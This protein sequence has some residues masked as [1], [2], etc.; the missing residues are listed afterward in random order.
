M[1]PN[2]IL[3]MTDQQRADLRRSRG[4]ELD[5]MPFLD[6]WAKGGVDFERSYTPNPICIAA[7]VS[8]FTGRTPETHKV[9]TNHN[10]MDATYTEDLLDVLRKNGYVTALCGK[11]HTHHRPAE[12]DFAKTNGHLGGEGEINQT[13]EEAEFANFLRSSNHMES[14]SPSPFGVEVQFPYR[15]VRDAL[16]FL[17]TRDKDRPFFLWVS[18][19]EPHNP[20]QV[21]EPY[22]DMFPPTELPE[23]SGPEALEHKSARMNWIRHT[24]EEVLG[25]SIEH[26]IKRT[27]SNYYGMLR[28]I[29]GQ[30]ERLIKGVDQRGLTDSTYI[31]YLSDHGDFV[32]EYGLLRKGGELHQLMIN[33]P[34]VWRGP[35]VVPRISRECISLIDFLPT[36]CE[37]IGAP[38]PEGV[39]GKSML[40]L[41]RGENT[42]TNE[43]ASAYSE[44]GFG[45]LIWSSDDLLTLEDEGTSDKERRRFDCLN[46][47]TQSGV[48]RALRKGD[49]KLQLDSEGEGYLFDLA[50]D[51]TELSNLWS[52]P[53]YIEVKA[54][55]LACL[56][57]EMMRHYDPLPYPHHRYRFKK[58]PLG[59]TETDITAND[60]GVSPLRSYKGHKLEN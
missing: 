29:D 22:F 53:S 27:R 52:D 33:I 45:G 38:I 7:R 26:R 57:K 31:I 6:E 30:L 14:D 2:F 25:D 16:Q 32:G 60:L 12:F 35:G 1:K 24:W 13:E 18:M 5:T 56:A 41:L 21:P 51:P 36:V 54:D 49:F 20:S 19:A 37:I 48:I 3:V 11:N 44:S 17:D 47:W 59:Y 46:T 50:N 39:Q 34:T 10:C 15:N 23:I 58:H 9:R 43:F 28:L 55:M 4:F 8:L 42:H 40:T